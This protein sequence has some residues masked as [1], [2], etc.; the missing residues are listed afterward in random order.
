VP[1]SIR[2]RVYMGKR[3]DEMVNRHN[4]QLTTSY[5]YSMKF[6]LIA[7]MILP[8][9]FGLTQE[10]S[11]IVT[12]GNES[13]KILLDDDNNNKVLNLRTSLTPAKQEYLTV[14]VSNEEIEKDWQ[15]NFIV[16]DEEDNEISRLAGMKENT[17]CVMLG[18]L[19]PLLKQ[20]KEY[21]LYTTALPKDPQQ[22]MGIKVS[23]Q[24]V[25]KI[26]IS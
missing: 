19:L 25:C 22:A 1:C 15:R 6:I 20:G 17:Y 5:L 18:K 16:Y 7:L 24:L 3:F 23:R 8:S 10:L 2:Q 9:A 21:S 12:A 14:R 4:L 26:K 13:I 11:I